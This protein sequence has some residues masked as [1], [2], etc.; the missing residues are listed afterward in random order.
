[1]EVY[2]AYIVHTVSP[3]P[4]PCSPTTVRCALGL[5]PP[6]R[7]TYICACI[8]VHAQLDGDTRHYCVS[9]LVAPMHHSLRVTTT[10]L[11]TRDPEDSP[12]GL[13]VSCLHCS[14]KNTANFGS[15]AILK[16]I[17]RACP[18]FSPVLISH[19]P[20]RARLERYILLESSRGTTRL[21]GPVLSQPP[22]PHAYCL[23][24]GIQIAFLE[25]QTRWYRGRL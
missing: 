12:Y 18:S 8:M 19:L 5:P 6:A 23:V 7:Y 13:N 16:A 22:G 15:L 4:H 11:P 10:S 3:A 2:G 1:M 21:L 17:G 25:R 14:A 24:L 20:H 9:F